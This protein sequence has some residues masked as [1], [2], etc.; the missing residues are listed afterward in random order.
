MTAGHRYQAVALSWLAMFLSGLL[1]LSTG[2]VLW[3]LLGVPVFVLVFLVCAVTG[4]LADER[5]V[6][7]QRIRDRWAEDRWM[8]QARQV[9]IEVQPDREQARR[10]LNGLAESIMRRR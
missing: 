9:E 6:R 2:A 10:W 3:V 4:Y 5:T 7:E 1:T 8:E